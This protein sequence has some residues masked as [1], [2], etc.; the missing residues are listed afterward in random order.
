MPAS[1][2]R[3]LCLPFFLR[4]VPVNDVLF[5]SKAVFCNNVS[6]ENT[7]LDELEWNY[8]VCLSHLKKDP[9]LHQ[10]VAASYRYICT[11]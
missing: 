1:L 10:F 3:E 11:Q 9:F 8:V 4:E 2:V 5:D 7:L 6:L